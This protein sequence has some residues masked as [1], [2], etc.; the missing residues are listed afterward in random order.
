MEVTEKL[1]V[2]IVLHDGTCVPEPFYKMIFQQID[3]IIDLLIPGI[4]YTAGGRILDHI[5]ST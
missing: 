3:P 1:E 2:N 4:P 5:V